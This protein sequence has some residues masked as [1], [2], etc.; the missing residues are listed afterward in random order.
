[1]LNLCLIFADFI[2]L[3]E[4]ERTKSSEK[5]LLK[6]FEYFVHNIYVIELMSNI[7][8][9]NTFSPKVN[10]STSHVIKTPL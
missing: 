2:K 8:L 6:Y 7:Q 4:L 1:M 10:I 3:R 5:T 9:C